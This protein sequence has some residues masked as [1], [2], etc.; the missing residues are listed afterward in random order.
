TWTP[1]ATEATH[2]KT[3]NSPTAVTRDGRLAASKNVQGDYGTCSTINTID[4]GKQLWRT[5]ENQVTGFTPNGSIAV[6]GPAYGD[7]YSPLEVAALDAKTGKLLREWGGG[8][9]F[10][11]TVVED[12]Q[13]FL[14]IADGGP[15]TPRG[16]IRC[17]VT[18]GGCEVAIPLTTKAVKLA[19]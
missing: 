12:D 10:L 7:G 5:C 17:N 16:V 15:E 9:S 11:E 2:T 13:H 8:P 19:R 4:V 1:G 14:I 18:T 3:I 6:G